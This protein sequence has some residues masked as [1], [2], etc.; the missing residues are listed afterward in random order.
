MVLFSS[1]QVVQY[2]EKRKGITD[3]KKREF[4][5]KKSWEHDLFKSVRRSFLNAH[6]V[7]N[8]S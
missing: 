6:S 2:V 1:F 5:R 4:P 7:V 8:C 3:R